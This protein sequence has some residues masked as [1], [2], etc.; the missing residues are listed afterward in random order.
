[1]GRRRGDPGGNP[2]AELNQACMEN[3]NCAAIL[4]NAGENG[5]DPSECEANSECT[6]L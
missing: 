2:Y 5:P 1:M 6:A 3:C 4:N